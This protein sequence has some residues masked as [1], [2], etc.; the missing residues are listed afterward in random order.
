MRSNGALSLFERSADKESLAMM[1]TGQGTI[2]EGRGGEM[3]ERDRRGEFKFREVF[4][5]VKMKCEQ[6]SAWQSMRE[7]GT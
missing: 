5:E 3:R 4:P 1:T 2:D 7:E 6:Y